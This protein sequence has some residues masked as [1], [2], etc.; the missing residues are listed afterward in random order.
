MPKSVH[1]TSLNSIIQGDSSNMPTPSI[2]NGGA[3]NSKFVQIPSSSVIT[4]FML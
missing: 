2:L 3:P 4:M 1:Q